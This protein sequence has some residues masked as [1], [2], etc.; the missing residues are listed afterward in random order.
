MIEKGLPGGQVINSDTVEN[1]PG[2]ES[3][4]GSDLSEKL[5]QH[6]KA[7]NLEVI[8]NEVVEV[9]PGLDFHSV[10]LDNGDVLKTYA[11]ILAM[12]GSPKKLE[13]PGETEYYG[14]GGSYCATCDGFFYRNMT[15]VVIGGGDSAM[16]EALYLAKLCKKIYLVH[17]RDELRASKILQRRVMDE[18]KI[19]ILWNTI[20]TEIKA[21]DQG[22][23][24]I[25]LQDTK[26]GSERTLDTHGVFVFIGFTPNSQLVPAGIEID[27]TGY[28][29]TDEKCETKIPGIYAIGDLRQ[30]YARRIVTA[31]GDGCTAALA[32]AHYVEEKKSASDTC[33]LPDD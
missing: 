27:T 33:E 21:D 1:Y 22:V 26:T 14:K 9:E 10:R 6:A 7:Y 32:A 30:K 24:A 11:L 23:S 29:I 3:V 18:C 13:I 15:V 5:L 28:V 12:G 20:P 16:E 2:F 31:A 25:S 4:T 19:E 17:R 8:Q